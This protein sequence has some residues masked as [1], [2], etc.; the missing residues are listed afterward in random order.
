MC[1]GSTVDYVTFIAPTNRTVDD[2]SDSDIDLGLWNV[3]LFPD[4]P[5]FGSPTETGGQLKHINGPGGS[6]ASLTNLIDLNE[7]GDL[8]LNASTEIHV[9]YSSIL[10]QSGRGLIRLYDHN[11]TNQLTILLKDASSYGPISNAQLYIK[12]AGD[13]L[14]YDYNAGEEK[15]FA[16]IS[17][18]IRPIRLY[19]EAGRSLGGGGEATINID[20][21]S[22]VINFPNGTSINQSQ[23]VNLSQYKLATQTFDTGIV[24]MNYSIPNN[25]VV[26][27]SVWVVKHG[28]LAG[29]NTSISSCGITLNKL[30]FRFLSGYN[31][32][33]NSAVSVGECLNTSSSWVNLTKVQYG[34]GGSISQIAPESYRNI[35][36]GLQNTGVSYNSSNGWGAPSGNIVAGVVYEE[37]IYILPEII[38][39]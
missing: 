38:Y 10:V 25:V 21:I 32:T 2:F 19:H 17:T 6:D 12:L 34:A 39:I 35:T 15:G 31:L 3:T 29:Y 16:N 33:D 11:L 36:D 5:N 28:I 9:D 1:T 4:N 8:F 27:D 7:N 18:W 37:F 13:N 22:R 20:D 24:F 30:S 14:S 23:S 26:N